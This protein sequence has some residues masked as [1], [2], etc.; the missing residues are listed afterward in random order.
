RMI[1]LP[2]A[3][4]YFLTTKSCDT[5]MNVTVKFP[6]SQSHQHYQ[7]PGHQ[8]AESIG[9]LVHFAK[10]RVMKMYNEI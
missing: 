6:S 10:K 9:E 3:Y 5:T 4:T 7:F 2:I 1:H 8:V